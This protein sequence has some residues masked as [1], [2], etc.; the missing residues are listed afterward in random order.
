MHE[1]RAELI[2]GG[3]VI[4]FAAAFLI[5]LTQ[6]T[7]L[8]VA[9]A[10]GPTLNANFRSA[11]GVSVGTDVR[12]AGVKIGTVT[13]LSLNPDTY[14]ADVAMRLVEGVPIPDDSVIVVATEGLLGGTFVEI[15][16][17]GSFDFYADGAT[18]EN[19]QGAVSVIA[20]LTKFV[21]GG[22]GEP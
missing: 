17:G 18:A 12:L 13:A 16:P 11:E 5:Y 20:L 7:G 14:R 1:Q 9:A 21:S 3:V 8:T 6:A 2:A 15:V 19:T 22:E 4:A 10:G